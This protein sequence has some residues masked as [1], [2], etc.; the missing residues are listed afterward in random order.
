MRKDLISRIEKI[1]GD[2][3]A[4]KIDLG[5]SESDEITD[6]YIDIK[7]TK[8]SKNTILKLLNLV[9]DLN[10]K[11][12]KKETKSKEFKEILIRF[13]KLNDALNRDEEIDLILNKGISND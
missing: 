9:N 1:L 2:I 7:T 3:H 8:Q 11:L 10:D 5:E 4:K 12:I 13:I 6:K